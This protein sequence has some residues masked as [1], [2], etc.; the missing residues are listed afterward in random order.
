MHRDWNNAGRPRLAWLWLVVI[1]L[2]IAGMP[3]CGVDVPPPP[4]PP[5][6]ATQNPPPAAPKDVDRTTVSKSIGAEGGTVEHPTGA[7]LLIPAG[8]LATATTMSVTGIEAPSATALGGPALGQGFQMEPD[9]LA[10]QKPI[11]V[12]LPFDAT[13]LPA[14]STVAQ[15]QVLTAPNGSTEFAALETTVDS[16]SGRLEAKT[17]HFSQYVPAQNA[18]PVFVTTKSPPSGT[19]G[20]AYTAKLEAIGGTPTYTWTTA[21]GGAGLPP[22][23]VLGKDGVLSGTPTQPGTFDF[24][25]LVT[26]SGTSRV[27]RAFS[28]LVNAATNPVP[29]ITGLSPRSVPQGSKDTLVTITGSGFVPGSVATW[30][31]ANLE[32]SYKSA[33][34][35]VALVPQT[36]LAAAGQTPIGVKNPAPGGGSS[37][38]IDFVVNAANPNPAPVLSSIAPTSALVG[39]ADTQITLTGASF[40]VSTKAVIGAQELSTSFVSSTQ[41]EAIIPASYLTSAKSLSVA[42][43]T[44]APGG[45]TSA[46]QT[47]IVGSVNPVPTITAMSPT[48]AAQGGPAFTLS[49]E[50]TGF[51]TGAQAFFAGTA[52]TTTVNSATS[53]SASVPASLLV[54]AGNYGI[55]LNNPAPGGGASAMQIFSVVAGN[56]VPTLTSISPN[57]ASAGSA[58]T[59]ITLT[60]TGFVS[61]A[62]VYF[63]ATAI[64]PTV[65]NATT[66]TATIPAVLLASV[67]TEQ[68]KIG[69]PGPGGGDSNT[70][71]FT[72]VA[73]ADPPPV[74][75]QLTPAEARV[76]SNTLSMNVWSN[77]PSFLGGAT[78]YADGTP[79]GTT[80]VNP[81]SLEAEIPAGMLITAGTLSI[82]VKNPGAGSSNALTFTT[83]SSGNAVPTISS[84]SP[85]SA[86]LGA[87]TP[88]TITITGTGFMNGGQ[89]ANTTAVYWR[90][91]GEGA[92]GHIGHIS[93]YTTV[94][95]SATQITITIP[96]GVVFD[97]A[98]THGVSVANPPSGGGQSKEFLFTV[99]GTN[100]VP[101]I[102]SIAPAGPFGTGTG[103]VALTLT[104]PAP[105]PS[106]VSRTV[107]TASAAGIPTSFLGRCGVLG[108]TCKV[109]LR[110]ALMTKAATFT[111]TATSPAPGGGAGTTATVTVVTGNPTPQL[112]ANYPVFPDALT[113]NNP[114][115]QR[116]YI[117]GSG[118]TAATTV[119]EVASNTTL[120]IVSRTNT[121][122][123]VDV[124]PSLLDGTHANLRLEI[125]NPSPG[126]GSVTTANIP[127]V[128][129]P[130]I[131][132]VMPNPVPVGTAFT[133]TIT[134]T[135]LD[136]AG[137][138]SIGYDGVNGGNYAPTTRT[139]TTWTINLPA[140]A[141]TNAGFQNFWVDIA[142]HPRSN[143]IEL[144][145]Q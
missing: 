75:A 45:G 78:V 136:L 85:S 9:G 98:G 118:F 44:P 73:A 109:T 46:A 72:I 101:D 48:Q 96:P 15:A 128:L 125:A 2:F 131:T 19:V 79:L 55:T 24:N 36:S 30:N 104:G 59:T 29:A 100:P 108:N 47:F 132:S 93:N 84:V 142:G 49:F 121:T 120:T 1:A 8:A 38:T 17:L 126:G 95:N 137:T 129:A 89:Q 91:P 77:A 61:G 22:G 41:L 143:T 57:Q 54:T 37:N 34:Q 141:F 102:A 68:V 28:I 130:I 10:F 88:T 50:G 51:V 127:V 3:G 66:A 97:T 62:K 21:P 105:G 20:A 56:P 53:A 90:M 23:I 135:N 111:I 4:A 107:V 70:Q 99:T 113:Q 64:A 133:M 82:T 119:R 116:V 58:D 69:N 134:G 123:Q 81:Y 35:V 106:F 43:S 32:T 39:A 6:P 92:A 76:G 52:L 63:G 122:L 14:G 27:Q 13:L 139:A 117:S 138:A 12:V 103:D 7:R 33:T 110:A 65:V 94:V 11:T 16:T 114:T 112:A 71:T 42:V 5:P 87:S 83:K 144:Q 60:G 18:N 86:A 40:I 80:W 124:P 67:G 26:D 25:V 74:I 115:A 31:G 145:S 140:T